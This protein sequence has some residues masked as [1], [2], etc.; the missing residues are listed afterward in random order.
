MNTM[1]WRG[2]KASRNQ[3]LEF[4]RWWRWDDEYPVDEDEYLDYDDI[5]QNAPAV[6]QEVMDSQCEI[7]WQIVHNG[8]L[9]KDDLAYA[10]REIK[11][12]GLGGSL[13]IEFFGGNTRDNVAFSKARITSLDIVYAYLGRWIRRISG[14]VV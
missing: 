13:E 2:A 4:P 14:G 5:T 6:P 11:S 9:T 10:E 3:R 7:M 12:F 8:I 1:P